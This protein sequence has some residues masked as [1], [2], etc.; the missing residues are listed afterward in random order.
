MVKPFK[1]FLIMGFS[2]KPKHLKRYQ[3]L[4]HLL[5]KYGSSD[6]VKQA[7]LEQAL[8]EEQDAPST[9][10]DAK[11]QDLAKDL[12]ALGPTF[13]KFG[14]LLSTRADLLP[15][16]YMEALADL[17]DE[18]EPFSFAE[19]EQL[20]EDELGVRIS[21]AFNVFEYIP[22]AA[23]SLGQV[24]QATLRDGRQVA[25]K[26]QRPGIRQQ[27]IDDLEVLEDV[28]GFIDNHTDFGKRFQFR[29]MLGAFRKSLLQELD[30]RQEAR[31]LDQIG[32]NLASF[33][34]IVI[35]EPVH[36]YT[37]SRVLTMDYIRGEKVTTLTPLR[38]LELDGRPLAEDVFRAYLQQILADGFFHADPHPGNVFLTDDN[39]IAL[40][41]LGMVAHIPPELQDRLLQLLLAVAECRAEEVAT[42]GLEIGEL[43][44]EANE[45]EFRK[46]ITNIVV[47]QQGATLE[48]L[49]V[50]TLVLEITQA[51]ATC[52]VLVPAELTMIGKTLLNLDHVGR[53]LDPTF[54]PNGAIRRNA[55][56]IMNQRMLKS[57]TPGNVFRQMIETKEL[58]ENLPNR[59]NRILDAAANNEFKIKVDAFDEQQLM[60]GLQKIANRIT[61][62]LVLAALVIGAALLMRIETAWTLFGYPGL[63]ILFFLL[64]GAGS[65]V[66]VYRVLFHDENAES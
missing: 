60:A 36:D 11:A 1:P 53:A 4:A 12:E 46:R 34:R 42:I 45:G 35:P 2:L 63:A 7:G 15:K 66:L 54:D 52:G 17:Q 13:V 49:E 64:A 38:L 48:D 26:V 9:S 30:Y 8:L 5:F 47:R 19:V 50:G 3:E 29:Q 59:V 40:I 58:I 28:A 10:T 22:L 21:K 20:V 14:Q 39:R 6:L 16:P 43:L 33:R 41:D 51:S 55:A 61:T 44:P 65:L 25:V 27:V 57:L 37:S 31:N 56:E 24:H 18:V 32:E 62:G 23:A